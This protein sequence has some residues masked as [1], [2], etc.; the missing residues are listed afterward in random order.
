MLHKILSRFFFVFVGL[1]ILSVP[2]PHPYMPD[3][4][5]WLH[6]IFEGL[7]KWT[8][9]H[10]L[11]IHHPYT[12]QL[13]SDS[14]GL[15][16]HLLILSII[17][18]IIALGWALLE[19]TNRN[20]EKFFYWFFV[21]ISYYLALQLFDYGFSKIFKWQFYLP[22]P[23]T[24]FITMGNTQRDLLYWS[25][26]GLSRPYTIFVGTMEVLAALLL[27][28]KRTRL[29]GALF[30]FF[31][32]SNVVAINFCYDISVKIFSCFLLLLCSSII[33]PDASRL[34]S[35][36]ICKKT[37]PQSVE[38]VAYASARSKRLY[39]FIK[40]FVIAYMLF[41]TLSVYFK[42]NNFNDDKAARPLFHGAYDVIV[43]VNN[44]D[45][46]APLL[47]DTTRWR[48]VFVHRQ[49]YF[50]TQDMQDNM[51]D[52]SLLI[53]TIQRNF[54]LERDGDTQ[55]FKLNYEQY[56]DSSLRLSGT[57]DKDSLWMKLKPIDIKKLPALQ[58]EFNWTI[59][60]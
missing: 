48:R 18:T 9:A 27:L 2:F 24:L 21:V 54:I 25:T 35:F 36:F 59:D 38:V 58:N 33:A 55:L 8:G 15:Y 50:I 46:L 56:P 12:T 4:A 34:F 19:K 23:N 51:Q 42:T 7:V 10:L 37:R 17:S 40:A 30:A 14:T 22:E 1:F 26:M 41:S 47:T 45:T 43:F 29:T 16:I 32:L 31:V 6:P 3:I 20:N 13:V 52:Y 44:G 11:N 39:Q 57:I 53:D 49:G 60:N 5:G 28:F